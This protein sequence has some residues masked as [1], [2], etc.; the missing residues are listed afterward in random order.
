MRSPK[1]EQMRED[2]A[3]SEDK[4][5]SNAVLN[6]LDDLEEMQKTLPQNKYDKYANKALTVLKNM[7]DQ[8][9]ENET[10]ED[11]YKFNL[12]GEYSSDSEGE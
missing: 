12:A 2:I 9:K 7:L 11:L 10:L 8:V 4:E 6:L 1:L 5:F 3:N